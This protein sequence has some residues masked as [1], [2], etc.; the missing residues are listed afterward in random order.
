L[1][2]KKKIDVPVKEFS[3][4]MDLMGEKLPDILTAILGTL[5]SET[6]GR[7]MGKAVGAFYQELLASGLTQALAEDMAKEYLQTM[8]QMIKLNN[9]KASVE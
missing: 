2:T 7:N 4:L 6:A 5:Y 1:E 9:R 8:A 3:A